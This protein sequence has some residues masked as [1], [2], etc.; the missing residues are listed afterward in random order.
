MTIDINQLK[1][2]MNLDAHLKNRVINNNS[3]KQGTMQDQ[4]QGQTIK[5]LTQNSAE[6]SSNKN[7]KAN[8]IIF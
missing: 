7:I 1:L 5:S 2:D 3:S 6:G 8:V 4:K